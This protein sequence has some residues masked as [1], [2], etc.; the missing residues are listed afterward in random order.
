[1]N[2]ISENQ[3]IAILTTSAG[4]ASAASW[5][6]A[7]N[8]A[9]SAY[10]IDSAP[11][12]AAFLATI[13]HESGEFQHLSENLHYSAQRLR[14]VW[15]SRFPDDDVA[16]AYANNPEKLANR[17]YASRLGN[18]DEA[19]GDGWKYRGRGLIQLTGK[20]NY[21]Q[22][23][24]GIDLDIV[25]QP[26]TLIQAGPAAKSAAWFWR[27]HGLNEMADQATGQNADDAFTRICKT[28]NGGLIGLQ[29]RM[30]IW[31]SARKVLDC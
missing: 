8:E 5:L 28:V 7:L 11:R 23:A 1:M 27:S 26:D 15:P 13:L 19:S 25:N 22:C 30:A 18:G 4:K 29:S 20:S 31:H 24:R 16:Q 17:V 9:M 2:T 21:E 14:Q 3:L 12:Q 6:S 10:A